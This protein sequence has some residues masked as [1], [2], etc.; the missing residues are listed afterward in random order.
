MYICATVV[1]QLRIWPAIKPDNQNEMITNEE[2]IVYSQAIHYSNRMVYLRVPLDASRSLKSSIS[3]EGEESKS[4]S[5]VT[6][7]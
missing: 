3:L 5:N 4:N 2:S 1:F 6:N 7:R